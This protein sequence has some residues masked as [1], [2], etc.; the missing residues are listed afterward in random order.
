[1]L[2]RSG[3]VGCHCLGPLVVWV[4]LLVGGEGSK[5]KAECE[6][7]KSKDAAESHSVGLCLSFRSKNAQ[8]SIEVA[9]L[10]NGELMI[11]GSFRSKLVADDPLGQAVMQ[12]DKADYDCDWGQEGLQ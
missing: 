3:I 11:R 1:M 12:F 8:S 5:S 9:G 7:A 10:R 6:A 4:S 2:A